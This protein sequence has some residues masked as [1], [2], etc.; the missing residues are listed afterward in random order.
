MSDDHLNM[1]RKLPT[2]L[3]CANCGANSVRPAPP[4]RASARG[5]R[6]AARASV[7]STNEPRKL[8]GAAGRSPCSPAAHAGLCGMWCCAARAMDD[9]TDR[10]ASLAARARR[11]RPWQA[12]V[13]RLLPDHL[14]L[15]LT[16]PR[17]PPRARRRRLAS[18]T[19]A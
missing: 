9:A 7:S 8:L 17:A 14:A 2:N 1:L 6:A 11:T 15:T 5:S 4:R 19:R 10:A 16:L 13:L 12:F 3:D 18:R